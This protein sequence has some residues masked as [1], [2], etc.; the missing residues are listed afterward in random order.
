MNLY[1]KSQSSDDSKYL[2]I[3]AGSV[4]AVLY[5]D[6]VIGGIDIPIITNRFVILNN[7]EKLEFL[8][9]IKDENNFNRFTGDG[10][11]IKFFREGRDR[12]YYIYSDNC[13]LATN[14]EIKDHLLISK[15]IDKIRD[16][17]N[18]NYI[19][20]SPE[21]IEDMYR[22]HRKERNTGYR[23]L[24]ADFSYGDPKKDFDY[25]EELKNIGS[26]RSTKE[27]FFRIK[28]ILEKARSRYDALIP[29]Y[30]SNESEIEFLRRKIEYFQD[31]LDSL[32]PGMSWYERSEV[33]K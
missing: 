30:E 10:S 3:E 28:S 32:R 22:R 7:N 21:S 33:D 26:L 29:N 5:D 4:I 23:K 15:N 14:A 8:K 6:Y 17:I 9:R 24:P 12:S 27:R 25:K 16:E 20:R 1:K 13:R 11:I 19:S 31:L 2:Y 18:R